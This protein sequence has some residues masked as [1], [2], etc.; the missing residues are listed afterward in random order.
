METAFAGSVPVRAPGR[1]SLAMR[2]GA[3]GGRCTRL[4]AVVRRVARW[5][6]HSYL[7]LW[8]IAVASYLG[9]VVMFTAV[10]GW[11]YPRGFGFVGA[12][13][14]FVGAAAGQSYRLHRRRTG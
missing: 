11:P 12:A 10:P 1:Y 5:Q 8:V 9:C 2:D 14:G 4:L 6:A 13:A 3:R 7:Q